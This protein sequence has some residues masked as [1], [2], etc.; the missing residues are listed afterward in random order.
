LDPTAIIVFHQAYVV[1]DLLSLSA[2][3]FICFRDVGEYL[4][5]EVMITRLLYPPIWFDFDLLAGY[6]ILIGGSAGNWPNP[7]TGPGRRPPV[8][9]IYCSRNYVIRV[10]SV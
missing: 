5:D 7:R 1:A 3:D 6:I 10:V 8:T 4:R 9:K 2:Q